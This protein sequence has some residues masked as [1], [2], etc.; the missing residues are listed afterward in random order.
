MKAFLTLGLV[1]L[2]LLTSA[3][4]QT[5]T[6]SAPYPT[7]SLVAFQ[8]KWFSDLLISTNETLSKEAYD[9]GYSPDLA[10]K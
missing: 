7:G 3:A 8:L 1:G 9:T 5:T 2:N 4:A 6:A 10:E